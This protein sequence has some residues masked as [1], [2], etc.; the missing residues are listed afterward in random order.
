MPIVTRCTADGCETLTIGPLC[1]D[2]EAATTRNFVRGR[3]FVPRISPT[4][5]VGV[6]LELPRRSRP[7]TSSSLAG[8]GLE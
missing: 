7:R 1:V 8:V 4:R 6:N 3:P 2:H 5:P